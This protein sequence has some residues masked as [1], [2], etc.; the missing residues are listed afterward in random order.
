[1]VST[2]LGDTVTTA[3]DTVLDPP[4]VNIDSAG[5]TQTMID[6]TM[7]HLNNIVPGFS[8]VSYSIDG[9]LSGLSNLNHEVITTISHLREPRPKIRQNTQPSEPIV[10]FESDR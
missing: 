9:V 7:D 6:P 8:Y 3:I 5:L 1:M 2:G 4:I 10:L